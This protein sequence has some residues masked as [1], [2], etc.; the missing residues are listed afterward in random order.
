[1]P[2]TLPY[3]VDRASASKGRQVREAP[4]RGGRRTRA[5]QLHRR[6]QRLPCRNAVPSVAGEQEV[7]AQVL[8]A[9]LQSGNLFTLLVRPFRPLV[10]VK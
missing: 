7:V 3:A 8:V 10:H 5:L 9:A 1:V 4:E 6:C 2:A